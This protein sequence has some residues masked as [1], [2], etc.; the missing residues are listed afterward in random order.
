MSSIASTRIAGTRIGRAQLGILALLLVAAAIAWLMT[1]ERMLG[2][3]AGPGTDPG[4]VGFYTV[5][6]VVM[7]AAMMFPS[8]APMVLTF[9]FIQRRRRERAT[10]ERT[11][12]SWVFVAGYL[13]T[14]TLFGLAAY[15]LLVALRSISLDVFSWHRG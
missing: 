2:M 1:R 13:A 5:S 14:W 12:S 8:I 15:G 4:G 10:L 11:T 3:D 7:M 6:W 9:A